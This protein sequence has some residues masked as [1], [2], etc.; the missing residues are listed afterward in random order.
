MTVQIYKDCDRRFIGVLGDR[1]LDYYTVMDVEKYK[2][3]R[4]GKVSP[5]RVNFE[6]RT[7][8]AL[9]STAVRWNQLNKNPFKSVNPL[10]ILTQRPSTSRRRTFRSS[11]QRSIWRGSAI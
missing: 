7:I 3:I 1:P 4:A 6:F 8:R 10:K 9:F 5:A 11:S 2:T